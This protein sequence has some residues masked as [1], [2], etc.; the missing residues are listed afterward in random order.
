MIFPLFL[1]P[2][3]APVRT[4]E[5]RDVVHKGVDFVYVITVAAAAIFVR[6]K[7]ELVDGGYLGLDL[8]LS[9][10]LALNTL[11]LTLE[12]L[13]ILCKGS[14][15]LGGWGSP[16]R[17]HCLQELLTE[18][19]PRLVAFSAAA[20]VAWVEFKVEHGASEGGHEGSAEAAPTA[21]EYGY[22]TVWY[23]LLASIVGGTLIPLG[24]YLLKW[25]PPDPVPWHY[26]HIAH[27]Y[28]PGP[29]FVTN[30]ELFPF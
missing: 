10:C 2:L 22:G 24:G 21:G 20:A 3:V 30:T 5:A 19:G 13:E 23:L 26:Q 9:L 17:R 18:C 29:P 28:G 7:A 4:F 14:R 12:K 11:V 16:A 1:R 25:L 15:R 8:G 27:R 6:P